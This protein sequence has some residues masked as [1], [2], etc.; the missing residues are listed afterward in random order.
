MVEIQD[1]AGMK[2]VLRKKIVLKTKTNLHSVNKKTSKE[3]KMKRKEMR[4]GTHTAKK[5]LYW[6]VWD[7]KLEKR[8]CCTGTCRRHRSYE[9]VGRQNVDVKV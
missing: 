7:S 5:N 9:Q 6:E 3:K 4:K 8:H 2:F 1:S